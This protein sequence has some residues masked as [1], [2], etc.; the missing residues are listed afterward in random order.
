M[1]RPCTNK[2]FLL[3]LLMGCTATLLPAQQTK[4][5]ELQVE[6][7]NVVISAA[8]GGWD[9]NAFIRRIQEDTTFYKAFKTTKLVSY[10]ATNKIVN[11]DNGNEPASSY[12]YT[13]RQTRTG[14][15]RTILKENEKVT[16]DFFDRNREPRTF[17]AKMYEHLFFFQGKLC[18]ENDIVKNSEEDKAKGRLEKTKIQLKQLI[19]NPG[20]KVDGVP[21]LGNKASLFDPEIAKLYKFQ[22]KSETFYGE[23]CYVFIATPKPGIRK[24][25]VFRNL[26]TWF[27]KSDYAIIARKYALN[28]STIAYDFDVEMEV[29]LTTVAGHLLPAKI[30]YTGNWKAITKSRERSSFTTSFYY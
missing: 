26:S 10:T 2:T 28:Y 8:R 6:M 4:H 20:S 3:L 16:G 24:D 7:D 23:D 18:G 25:L 17:T 30:L 9:V 5:F 14:K 11:F 19:F 1:F 27:R 29:Y 13:S 21:L 22:L 12:S 15:C